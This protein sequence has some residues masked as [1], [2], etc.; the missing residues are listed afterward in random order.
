[1][2]DTCH[3]IKCTLLGKTETIDVEFRLLYT[4]FQRYEEEPLLGL[5]VLLILNQRKNTLG[6][7]G[8]V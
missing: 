8:G 3:A 7:V 5:R 1:M 6:E 4:L 2:V